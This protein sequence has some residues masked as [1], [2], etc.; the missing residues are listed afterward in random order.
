ME[1]IIDGKD[2]ANMK[3]IKDSE[4]RL[5]E[6]KPL[7]KFISKMNEDYYLIDD[8][9]NVVSCEWV[10][11][12]IDKWRLKHYKLFRTA[13]ECE[14]YKWFLEMVDKYSYEFSLEEWKNRNIIKYSIEYNHHDGYVN[15]L[16]I[17]LIQSANGVY[18]KSLIDGVNFAKEVGKER[19]MKY[20]CNIW[21]F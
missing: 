15:C 3:F 13:K 16:D 12:D 2:L 4:G 10:N 14:D 11:D 1:N 18:F 8:S 17:H 21:E 19:I 6:Y 7:G 9:G 5:M 20:M